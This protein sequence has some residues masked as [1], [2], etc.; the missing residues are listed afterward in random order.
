MVWT[1]RSFTLCP[2]PRTRQPKPQNW[3]LLYYNRPV[4]IH[5]LFVSPLV[6]LCASDH[7][8]PSHLPNSQISTCNQKRRP[9]CNAIV[10]RIHDSRP[11]IIFPFSFSLCPKLQ[12]TPKM[13]QMTR[14]VRL[15]ITPLLFQFS[16]LLMLLAH[17]PA[18][19]R[20]H[21]SNK[22]LGPNHPSAQHLWFPMM[23]VSK[24]QREGR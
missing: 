20:L 18:L 10:A 24:T 5:P 9:I 8:M 4:S 3:D 1:Q 16:R 7:H 22:H 15:P 12:K 11:R 14:R 13:L 17:S 23:V 6:L 2:E 21:R 19:C